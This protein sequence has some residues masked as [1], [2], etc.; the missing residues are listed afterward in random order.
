M[1]LIETELKDEPAIRATLMDEIAKVYLSLGSLEDAEPL[2]TSALAIR[3]QLHAEQPNQEV[4]E[5][6]MGLAMT[7]YIQGNYEESIRLFRE[8]VEIE[9]QLFGDLDPRGAA[10]KLMFAFVLLE[11]NLTGAR[12][13]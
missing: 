8:A 5:T 10:L 11:S 3:R 6:L 1:K 2:L 12:G 4:A 7:R 9:N 13:R